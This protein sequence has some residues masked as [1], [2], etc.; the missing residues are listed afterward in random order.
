MFVARRTWWCICMGSE[1]A[2]GVIET[3]ETAQPSVLHGRTASGTPEL[4]F[5][6]RGLLKQESASARRLRGLLAK[7]SRRD[8]SHSEV[9][10]DRR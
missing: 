6:T 8:Q 7:A 1:P 3:P 4:L 10:T 5:Y 2:F 9:A